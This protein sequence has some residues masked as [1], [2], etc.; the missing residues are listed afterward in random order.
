MEDLALLLDMALVLGAAV[1]AG[2]LA[3]RLGQPV[4]VGY[5]LAGMVVGPY[6]LGLVREAATVQVLATV[7]VVLL[8]FTLGVEF[9][10][11]D[12]ARIG[13]VAVLGGTLQ[14]LAT[15]ALGALVAFALDWGALP[16]V[17]F[18]F[19]LAF[20]S[21]A[22]ILKLLSDRGELDAPHGRI[23]L[24]IALVQ[25]LAVVPVMVI[26]P[27]LARPQGDL[28]LTLGVAAGKAVVLLVGAL[29]LGTRVM[30][31]LLERVALLRSRELFLLA[32]LV[33]VLGTAQGTL[34]FGLSL[35]FGAFLAGLLV[36][37]SDYAQQA[38]A[39]IMPLRDVFASL[40]FVSLGML[41]DPRFLLE[42]PALVALVVTLLVVGK[43]VLTM[44]VVRIFGYPAMTAVLVGAGLF[45]VGEFS[46][47]LARVGVESGILPNG[48]YA[49]ILISALLTMLLTA[50]VLSGVAS[51]ERRANTL[52]MLHWLRHAEADRAGA[53]QAVK[54]VAASLVN[55]AVICGY[56][57]VGR[58]VAEALRRRGLPFVVVDIDARRLRELRDAGTPT[59]YGDA[60]SPFV[61]G[62]CNLPRA[63]VL[64][65]AMSDPIAQEL[66]LRNA[67]QIAPRLD[68]VARMIRGA[69]WDL[70]RALGASE[71]VQPEFEAG[72]EILR[73]TLHRFGVSGTEVQYLISS[74]RNE[75]AG[76]A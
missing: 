2:A 61:L 1:V 15:A 74:I 52:Q 41:T 16:A 46:F 8:L 38:L 44:G 19:L 56:G 22:V 71:V 14:V 34:L 43:A 47:V 63:R 7:G 20:S 4:L 5:L 17:Y 10:L 50:P 53:A 9:S 37:E 33:L 3:Q 65:L 49:L 62:Q 24:G 42:A 36:S 12:L 23:S 32:V 57:R 45:Q 26:L 55:H 60:S 31:W 21:T 76:M 11:A 6:G 51:L 54:G 59:V 69:D 40:F 25:D 64:V 67:R 73:H 66:A 28:L 39:E 13:P 68:V 75:Q 27:A 72:M 48:V 30:P 18:G 70:L 58:Q 35:A 29:L